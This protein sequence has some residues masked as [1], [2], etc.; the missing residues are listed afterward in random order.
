[1]AS[2]VFAV[3]SARSRHFPTRDIQVPEFKI[4]GPACD[5]TRKDYKEHLTSAD[6]KLHIL[7]ARDGHSHARMI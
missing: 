3:P 6:Q 4:L 2:C 1:M 7:A 5:E